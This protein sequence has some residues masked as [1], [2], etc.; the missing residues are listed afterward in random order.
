MTDEKTGKT[1]Y[2]SYMKKNGEISKY[3]YKLRSYYKPKN[4]QR[5]R[6]KLFKTVVHELTED[7]TREKKLEILTFINNQLENPI[8]LTTLQWK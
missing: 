3:K 6:K 5:G 8:D 2:C 1:V 7:M 4:V